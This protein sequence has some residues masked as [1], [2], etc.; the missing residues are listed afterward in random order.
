MTVKSLLAGLLAVTVCASCGENDPSSAQKKSQN[1]QTLAGSADTAK[2]KPAA[3]AAAQNQVRLPQAP[4]ERPDASGTSGT[5]GASGAGAA[6]AAAAA[7][8]TAG[9]SGAPDT[10]DMPQVPKEAR[11]T[12][13]CTTLPDPDHV[14]TSRRLKAA[15]VEKTKLREWYIIH[16]HDRSRLYYGY[17]RSIDDP[18]DAAESARAKNDRK[19]IDAIV[20]GA[21][22]RPFRSCQ[23]VQ[24]NSPDPESRPEWNLVNAPAGMT[25][26]LLVGAYKDSADRKQA[27]VD[28]VREAREKY[29]L[30]AYYYHGETVSNVCIGAWPADAV[31][32]QRDDPDPE[33][34]KN[35][36]GDVLVLPPGMKAPAGAMHNGK[37]VRAVSQRMVVVNESLKAMQEKYPTCL[38]NG[39]EI[40]YKGRTG[41]NQRE[42]SH[43]VPIPRPSESL[44]ADTG[45]APG[46]AAGADKQPGSLD[47]QSVFSKPG[48]TDN[49]AAQQQQ[50]QPSQ[51]P[52]GQPAGT[53][54]GRLR[55]L[56]GK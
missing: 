30:E 11:W 1:N 19:A 40:I 10:S 31:I 33:A 32:E 28:A 4:I 25:W 18:G 24:L 7:T 44:F 14:N 3:A 12:I 46:A 52:Q 13:Y 27:A 54:S 16:E 35:G 26:T 41:K 56:S 43:V 34:S 53:T 9:G 55:S 23:F 29:G 21:G 49:K 51:P 6:A 17:Y 42:P 20:D 22:E 5:S 37:R 50:Q 39:E 47:Q 38:V 48:Y 15:L 36:T 2:A 45:G 8:P